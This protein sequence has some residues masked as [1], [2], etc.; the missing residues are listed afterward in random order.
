MMKTFFRKYPKQS[1]G[2]LL[3]VLFGI[4]ILANP[5]QLLGTLRQYYKQA[6]MEIRKFQAIQASYTNAK[7]TV[8]PTE[9]KISP[10]DGMRLIRIP[11]GEFLMGNDDEDNPASSPA[12]KV[13]LSA[14]WID[15]T[16]VTN[17]MY[18]K[19]VAEQECLEPLAASGLNP[20]YGK[21]AHEN[22]PVIYASWQYA[23]MY[24]TWAG[25]RLPTEAE[26]EKAAR[27][28]DGRSYPWGE[29][30]PAM[31][32]L[33]FDANIG[34]PVA[35][36][37]YPLG[38]SPYG[39]LNMAGNV[40]EW[41]ADWFS[42]VYYHDLPYDNPQGPAKGKLKSLRGGA[43]DDHARE[44]RTFERLGHEPTSAGRNRGFRCAQSENP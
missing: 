24:C 40:R 20:Y 13:Y 16:E 19:C 2:L 27:G 33:N 22:D 31:D 9:N 4:I 30:Q 18:A 15:Q 7:A 32:L 17:A 14:F 37:R 36:D 6:V 38:A 26:W 12:H 23:R 5:N 29:R 35:A 39:V 21:A 25:R 43:F 41:V 44:S 8:P 28:T 1:A 11:E 42:P 10:K 34:Q 3:L